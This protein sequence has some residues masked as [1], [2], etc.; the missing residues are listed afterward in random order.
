MR[1]AYRVSQ[2]DMTVIRPL[3]IAVIILAAIEILQGAKAGI[4]ATTVLILG[5][6]AAILVVLDLLLSWPRQPAQPT[7]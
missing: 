4:S 7:P 5:I 2:V 6:I 1:A 3:H